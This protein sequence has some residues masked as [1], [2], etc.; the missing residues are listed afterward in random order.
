[1]IADPLATVALGRDGT[2][3]KPSDLI[4][5]V[6]NYAKGLLNYLLFNFRPDRPGAPASVREND[7]RLVVFGV[8]AAITSIYAYHLGF[9]RKAPEPADVS[10]LLMQ[11]VLFWIAGMA[12]VVILAGA[13]T[14][15]LEILPAFSSILRVLPAASL[16]AV[17]GSLLVFYAAW[18]V[19]DVKAASLVAVCALTVIQ[20]SFVAWFLPR[21]MA[22]SN[23]TSL[24]IRVLATVTIV[25]ITLVIHA[26]NNIS[27]AKAAEPPVRLAAGL[28]PTEDECRVAGISGAKKLLCN[29]LGYPV[30]GGPV[31]PSVPDQPPAAS[32][33]EFIVYFPFNSDEI[34]PEG[35]Q[36]VSDALLYA[37]AG[38]AKRIVLIGHSD[39]SGSPGANERL[40]AERAKGVADA[41]TA[42]GVDPSGLTVAWRGE[43]ELAVATGDG[44]KEPL[45][46]R[47]TIM[48][49]F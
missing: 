35:E 7:I 39:A 5:F 1:M 13:I 11:R 8:L 14:R 26:I 4:E 19:L 18:F 41:L 34:G 36:V 43:A 42:R 16:W 17:I 32:Q 20:V 15:R 24:R 45:N 37:A 48:I 49:E 10:W 44:T 25:L 46:R 33:R 3:M 2:A 29:A 47:V 21:S 30:A 22:L 31:G 27:V 23:I 12:V 40:S 38:R 9:H 28:W 6:Q